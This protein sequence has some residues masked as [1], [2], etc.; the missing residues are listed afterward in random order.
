MSKLLKTQRRIPTRH[1]A[2]RTVERRGAK[3]A[4]RCGPLYWFWILHL[5]D[6]S[7]GRIRAQT[8]AA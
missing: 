7:A 5:S 1:F 4:G 8:I 3:C 2:F 6:A